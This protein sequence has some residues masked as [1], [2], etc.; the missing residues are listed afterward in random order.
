MSNRS[1]E[2]TSLMNVS[3][4]A[5]RSGY[6][7]TCSECGAIE[8]I[9]TNTYTGSMA[10]EGIAA[11]FRN[12]GWTVSSRERHDVCPACME[13]KKLK[14]AR[15]TLVEQTSNIKPA[16]LPAPAT[17]TGNAAMDQRVPKTIR[18]AN[19]DEF[20]EINELLKEHLKK[21]EATG[22]WVYDEG[23][24][25][26]QIAKTVDPTLGECSVATLRNRRFGQLQPQVPDSPLMARVM[27]L[28][29]L[30]AR[31]YEKLGEKM[32]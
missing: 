18:R 21:D 7:V 31:L 25:D 12:K 28:E 15:L 11:R 1:F 19:S 13:K 6:K 4:S 16:P 2:R 14:P 3:G 10:P 29:A 27:K 23:W 20:I 26:L 5:R 17:S 32:A 24:S 30:V 8:K 22:Y 9:A